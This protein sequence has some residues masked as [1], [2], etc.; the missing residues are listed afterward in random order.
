MSCARARRSARAGADHRRAY[1]F[2]GQDV[3]GLDS[4]DLIQ[5]A[6]R[7][8]RWQRTWYAV[9]IGLSTVCGQEILN[10]LQDIDSSYHDQRLINAAWNPEFLRVRAGWQVPSDAIVS[11]GPADRGGHVKGRSRVGI[12]KNPAVIRRAADAGR[13]GQTIVALM[14]FDADIR[15]VPRVK[16]SSAGHC[17]G[18]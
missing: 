1:T 11:I 13:R 9:A 5:R 16:C 10:W 4:A 7:W 12:R 14:A 15:I 6:R 17:P 8:Q 18:V 3:F 2:L